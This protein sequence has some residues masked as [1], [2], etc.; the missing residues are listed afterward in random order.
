MH[1]YAC[2]LLSTATAFCAIQQ[3]TTYTLLTPFTYHLHSCI[4]RAL[5]HWLYN[6]NTEQVQ[7]LN[8][9]CV[10]IFPAELQ[11]Y[12]QARLETAQPLVGTPAHSLL[13]RIQQLRV[14]AAVATKRK[15]S[16]SAAAA[17]VNGDAASDSSSSSSS[18]S[19]SEAMSTEAVKPKR[20]RP[21]R[22]D[23][24]GSSAAATVR[25]P[26]AKKADASDSSSSD[27]SRSSSSSGE[28]KVVKPR[29][30]RAVKAALTS[31]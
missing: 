6:T 21:K 11:A 28:A 19:S 25:K 29:A 7:R 20:G 2:V 22:V 5:Y 31:E 9:G 1:S 23:A 4:V 8:Q 27:S 12:A 16:T 17:R 30:K 24:E 18:S 14:A 26:R 3:H 13:Q 10:E 15:A